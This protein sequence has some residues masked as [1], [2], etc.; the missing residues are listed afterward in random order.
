MIIHTKIHIY[1][2]N[3]IN[4]LRIGVESLVSPE[5]KCAPKKVQV[6]FQCL[7][8]I[9]MTTIRHENI[10]KITSEQLHGK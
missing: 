9:T 2:G 5:P 10:Q 4:W 1:Q 7:H 8:I 3:Y 6:F